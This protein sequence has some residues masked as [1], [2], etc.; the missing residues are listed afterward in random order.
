MRTR[1]WFFTPARLYFADVELYVF[2]VFFLL[3]PVIEL[4]EMILVLVCLLLSSV[5]FCQL[6]LFVSE[7]SLGIGL[8][9]LEEDSERFLLQ[10]S[11]LLAIVEQSDLILAEDVLDLVAVEGDRRKV[12]RLSCHFLNSN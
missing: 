12:K 1:F 2:L 10:T 5:L 6:L 3:V 4:V 9:V 7:L 8:V 11:S